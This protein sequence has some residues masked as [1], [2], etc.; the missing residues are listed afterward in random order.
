MTLLRDTFKS[1][2]E[3]QNALGEGAGVLLVLQGLIHTSPSAEQCRQSAVPTPA[4]GRR[5]LSTLQV[6]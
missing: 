3:S 2:T 1:F 4:P 6:S 5:T